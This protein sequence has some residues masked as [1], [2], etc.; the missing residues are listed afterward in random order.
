MIATEIMEKMAE[1]GADGGGLLATVIN[2][3]R[4]P[5]LIVEKVRG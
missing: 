1:A 2:A 3:L 5:V 4:E